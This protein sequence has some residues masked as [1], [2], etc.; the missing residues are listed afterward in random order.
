V[1]AFTIR[2]KKPRCWVVWYIRLSPLDL[3][4]TW[5]I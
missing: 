2:E 1:L 5:T 4:P 3:C